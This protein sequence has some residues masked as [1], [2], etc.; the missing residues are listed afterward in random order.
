M[1]VDGTV[2][3]G[4]GERG[5]PLPSYGMPSSPNAPCATAANAS[6]APDHPRIGRT[7]SL[8]QY[9]ELEH[10]QVAPR[11]AGGGYVDELLARHA[12]QRRIA[13]AVPYFLAALALVAETDYLLTISIRLAR[14]LA[15]RLGLRMIAP[16]RAPGLEPYQIA[17]L[18]HPR[19]DRDAAHR[20]LREAVAEAGRSV[21]RTRS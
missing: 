12:L 10:V 3:V 11:G 9:A 16:P 1:V 20:W 19:N 13:R 14:R 8:A 21:S 7:L 6:R 2:A 15:P 17:Q 4:R 18:W 5:G